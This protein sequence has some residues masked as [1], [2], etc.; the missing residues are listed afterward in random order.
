VPN[1]LLIHQVRAS[2]AG[3]VDVLTRAGRIVAA[4]GVC[5]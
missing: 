2:G 3:S 1:D 5:R 4:D